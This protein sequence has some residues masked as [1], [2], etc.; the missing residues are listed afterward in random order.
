MKLAA[1]ALSLTC[2]ALVSLFAIPTPAQYQ[3][4]SYHP[5]ASNSS[6]RV[7][8]ESPST[9]ADGQLQQEAVRSDGTGSDFTSTCKY[10][11]TS[12]ATGSN[13]YLQYCVTVNGNIAEFQSPKGI[14][15]IREGTVGEGYG[16]CDF[17]TDTKYFDW[18]GA[19]DSGS[20]DPPTTL[21]QTATMV[22][23]ERITIDGAWTLTQTFTQNAA[24]GFVKI[25]MTLKN[26][27][28]ETKQVS[29][30]RWADVYADNDFNSGAD[31]LDGM[32]NSSWA[33]SASLDGF[34]LLLQNDSNTTYQ[35]NGW[36]LNTKVPPD[37]CN[38]GL[39]AVNAL[40]D[41]K[42]SIVMWY[43]INTLAK[44]KI[45]TVSVKYSAF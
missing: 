8:A 34:G 20:W 32:T 25:P 42:G 16:I 43:N 44:D 4:L 5:K 26:N 23:I 14:E 18:A 45:G 13:P 1:P 33:Y 35:H 40:T 27:S 9:P 28:S 17:T 29:L 15:S 6:R 41:T 38:P 37:P 12:G 36:A 3:A 7:P 39:N 31:N 2:V 22:K 21:T 11:F 10:T 30:L 24:G 19:G